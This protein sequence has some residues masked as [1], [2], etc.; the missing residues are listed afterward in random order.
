[1]LAKPALHGF[2]YVRHVRPTWRECE[3]DRQADP[4]M[5][6]FPIPVSCESRRARTNAHAARDLTWRWSSERTREQP[7]PLAQGPLAE[8]VHV[9]IEN[10]CGVE[11]QQ[12]ADD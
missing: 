9:K 3:M 10:G 7:P 5:L 4:P 1:M 12:L 8:A 6:T 11:R 2:E